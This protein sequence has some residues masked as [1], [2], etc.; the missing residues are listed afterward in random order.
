MLSY[1]L[2]TIDDIDDLVSLRIIFLQEAEEVNPSISV[3]EM[4]ASLYNYFKDKISSNLFVSWLAFDEEKIVA[5]SGMSF[6]IV[7]PSHGNLTGEEAYLMN[8]YTL[9]EYRKQGIGGELLNRT[10]EEAWKR[11]IRK[12]RLN[13]TAIGRSLYE[14]RGFKEETSAMVLRKT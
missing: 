9:P 4:K 2:A 7:P 5:T 6:H 3:D 11:G 14:K 1:R 10:I 13:A 8:M 12:I